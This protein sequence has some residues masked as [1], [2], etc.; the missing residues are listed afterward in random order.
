MYFMYFIYY[1]CSKLTNSY[2]HYLLKTIKKINQTQFSGLV[3]KEKESLEI[4]RR[5]TTKIIAEPLA[6]APSP[7][8]VLTHRRAQRY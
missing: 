2:K 7:S 4:V 5:L 3:S 8:L 1:K 6:P